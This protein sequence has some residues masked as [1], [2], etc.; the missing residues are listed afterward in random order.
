MAALVASKSLNMDMIWEWFNE[1][2]E[3]GSADT[4]VQRERLLKAYNCA[5]VILTEENLGR[6]MRLLSSSGSEKTVVAATCRRL[7]KHHSKA[8]AISS[9]CEPKW[10]QSKSMLLTHVLCGA[11]FIHL[12]LHLQ[13]HYT[14]WPVLESQDHRKTTKLFF[15]R[16]GHN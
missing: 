12:L 15:S 4:L 5:T 14:V 13:P 3:S 9:I 16:R 10:P 1:V 6:N 8:F 7:Q 2:M 11:L